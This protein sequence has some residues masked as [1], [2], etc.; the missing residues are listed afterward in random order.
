MII[1][2]NSRGS[3]KTA[4]AIKMASSTHS[5]LV[6]VNQDAADQIKV[7][8]NE[9]GYPV[10]VITMSR[11]FDPRRMGRPVDERI[12]ID[13]LDIVLRQLFGCEVIMA[14]TTG[15]K[16]DIDIK[17]EDQ[18]MTIDFNSKLYGKF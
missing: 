11:Y 18:D 9:M 1:Y 16:V 8:A 7:L 6:V 17:D 12:I 15:C 5:V 13:D 4:N 10:D 14:T 2:A 3:E